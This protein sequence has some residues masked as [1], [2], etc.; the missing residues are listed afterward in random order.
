MFVHG[1]HKRTDFVHHRLE[2]RRGELLAAVAQRR[3]R[4]GMHFHKQ[5]IRA[6][7]HGSARGGESLRKT[8]SFAGLKIRQSG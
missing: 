3:C 2:L 1:M 4:A 6:N 5:S 8:F 7:R